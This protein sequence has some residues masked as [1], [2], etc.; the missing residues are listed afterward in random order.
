DEWLGT[1]SLRVS[2]EHQCHDP[3]TWGDRLTFVSIPEPYASGQGLPPAQEVMFPRVRAQPVNQ[4]IQLP[5]YGEPVH[6]PYDGYHFSLGILTMHV[7][8]DG[9][10]LPV[11]PSLAPG[12]QLFVSMRMQAPRMLLS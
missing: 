3:C 1:V 8:D 7:G 10:D 2:G 5:V 11:D 6:Y 12:Q 4:T 9:S